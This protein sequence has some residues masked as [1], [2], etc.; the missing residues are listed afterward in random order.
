MTSKLA[1]DSRIDPR[2]KMIFGQATILAP[3]GNV[4]DRTE[5]LAYEASEEGLAASASLTAMFNMVDNEYVAPSAGLITRTERFQS[6]PDGNW[7]NIQY[8]RPDTAEALPC[9]YYIHGGGMAVMSCFDGPYRAWGRIIA[10]RGVAVAMVDFRNCLR[11][12]SAPEVEPFPAERLRIR[13]EVGQGKQRQ[14]Q[15]RP[16]SYRRSWRKW[17]WQSDPCHGAKTQA[18]RRSW[19]DQG[20]LCALPLYRR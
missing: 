17:R 11:A 2:I 8:I 14:A 7:I 3:T 16:Q 13:T 1:N 10:A 6:A 18:G 4:K 20:A 15:Y 12:S 19:S 9:V 5:L